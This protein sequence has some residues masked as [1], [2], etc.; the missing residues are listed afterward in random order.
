M[1]DIN[2]EL[3]QYYPQE[4]PAPQEEQAKTS[5]NFPLDTPAYALGFCKS[6]SKPIKA[7]L[8]TYKEEGF[9]T[10]NLL[11]V[12]EN[13]TEINKIASVNTEFAPTKLMWSANTNDQ[14]FDIVATT[15]DCLRLYKM[16][17][18]GFGLEANLV[19]TQQ[20]E[21]SAP[22]TSFDWNPVHPETICCAAIDTT[23]SIW[24]I[25]QQ[26]LTKLIIAHDKEVFDV[27]F[28]AEGNYF[29]TVGA[30]CTARLFDI[31]SLSCSNIIFEHNEPL[32]RILWNKKHNSNLI[33]LVSM[34]ENEIILLDI[35]HP[36]YPASTL[37]Y[38]KLPVNNVAWSSTS[39][40]Q[41]C[42]ISM[43]RHAYLWDIEKLENHISSPILEY[44]SESD[45]YNLSWCSYNDWIGINKSDSFIMLKIIK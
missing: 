44:E 36:L 11:Q 43:D 9:N 8:G 1:T 6:P 41:L 3:V 28:A 2:P 32:V 20:E 29:T 31:R 19:N 37:K 42:S 35:R 25:Q 16:T 30:D 34:L 27:S 5:L 10:I 7:A 22:L 17:E 13:R 4:P 23:C 38:H 26:K 18:T 33:A 45:L 40:H 39:P 24:D 21:M 15:S 14:E 12:N